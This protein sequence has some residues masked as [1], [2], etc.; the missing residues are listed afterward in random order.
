M[1][2]P[3]PETKTVRQLR[4]ACDGGEGALGHP[5]VWL[6]IPLEQGW[7]ECSYCDARYVLDTGLPEAVAEDEV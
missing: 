2:L 4:V 5:R 7:V 6:Q 1:T 3:A